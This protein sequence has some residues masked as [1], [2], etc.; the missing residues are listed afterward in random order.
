MWWNER[1]TNLMSLEKIAA[2]RRETLDRI[3]D[4]SLVIET[5]KVE[6]YVPSSGYTE[7]THVAINELAL[8]LRKAYAVSFFMAEKTIM[9]VV[10]ELTQ[11]A[12]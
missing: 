12:N 11:R 4:G 9:Q 6:L 10:D 2:I 7:K 1:I 8:E 3:R 5:E